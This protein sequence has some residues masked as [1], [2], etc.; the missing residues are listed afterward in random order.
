[1]FKSNDSTGNSIWR[2]KIE[3]LHRIAPKMNLLEAVSRVNQE[4]DEDVSESRAY[5]ALMV[6]AIQFFE[7]D[8]NGYASQKAKG[9]INA[10]PRLRWA[11]NEVIKIHCGYVCSPFSTGIEGMNKDIDREVNRLVSENSL[12]M[13][14]LS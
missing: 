8:E 10:N 5:A 9:I 1:M 14:D 13:K 11:Y 7:L 12:D 6:V 2:R 3:D 4:I